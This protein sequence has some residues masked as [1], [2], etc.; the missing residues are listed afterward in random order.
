[1]NYPY[2]TTLEVFSHLAGSDLPADQDLIE[3]SSQ[4]LLQPGD[5]LF[6]TGE[7]MPFAFAVNSGVV[8]FVYETQ[9]GDSWIKG[10]A[11]TGVCFASLTALQ[12]NGITS[13]SAYAVVKSRI[14]QIEYRKLQ[15]LADHYIEWQRAISNVFKYYGQR[16]EQREMELLT[17]SPE[18]R[19][20]GFLREHPELAARIRQHDIASYIRVTSVSLSRIRAR[21]KSQ[22]RLV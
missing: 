5:V 16:K 3:A 4:R 17:M 9:A 6:H 7:R 10:F 18:E 11:E 15:Q 22:G 19:Y 21:L 13:F 12:G 14:D 8:K 20:L 1:M 2:V